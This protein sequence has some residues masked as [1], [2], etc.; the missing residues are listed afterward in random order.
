[1]A[2]QSVAAEQ[3]AAG[4]Q[5]VTH[6]IRHRVQ[7]L[8]LALHGPPTVE[9]DVVGGYTSAVPLHRLRILWMETVYCLRHDGD[10]TNEPDVN[11][12]TDGELVWRVEGVVSEIAIVGVSSRRQRLVGS[13]ISVLNVACTSFFRVAIASL[14][15]LLCGKR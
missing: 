7:T 15:L 11:T 6:E 14:L 3:Q 13:P 4:H 9:F 1:M 5:Q 8:A 10:F 12:S 2:L